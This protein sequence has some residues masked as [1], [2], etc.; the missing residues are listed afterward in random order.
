MSAALAC[1][2]AVLLCRQVGILRLSSDIGCL[3]SP[4]GVPP[5]TVCLTR[6]PV[7]RL[8]ISAS[9]LQLHLSPY[10]YQQLMTVLQAATASAEALPAA[11]AEPGAGGSHDQPLWLSEAEHTAKVGCWG[12][13]LCA[14]CCAHF[15]RLPGAARVLGTCPQLHAA[16]HCCLHVLVVQVAL[17]T[18]EGL[19]GSAKWQTH[20]YVHVWRGRL[21][22]TAQRDDSE[23]LLSKTFWMTYSVVQLP[24][25]VRVLCVWAVVAALPLLFAPSPGPG[26]LACPFAAADTRAGR[27][28]LR[29]RGGCGA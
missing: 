29:Q 22:L 19:R 28:R 1:A 8:A 13:S 18:W 4:F 10:R 15:D 21:Y 6:F 20:R 14:G 5:P 9:P 23:A 3:P 7:V 11:A 16:T 27:R 17:L 25:A 26:T 24:P 12:H 2:S